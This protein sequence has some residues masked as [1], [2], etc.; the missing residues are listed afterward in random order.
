[1]DEEIIKD[2]NYLDIS[3]WLESEGITREVCQKLKVSH[4]ILLYWTDSLI[5]KLTLLT[6]ENEIDG[7]CFLELTEEDIRSTVPKIGVIK[8]NKLIEATIIKSE[9][10][11]A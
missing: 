9:I 11:V 2:A 5:Y 1:M 7:A 8:K 3:R 4:A 10:T 6:L